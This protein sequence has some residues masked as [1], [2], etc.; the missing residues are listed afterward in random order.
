VSGYI[1]LHPQDAP[2]YG[3]PGAYEPRHPSGHPSDHPDRPDGHDLYDPHRGAGARRI[4]VVEDDAALRSLVAF[5]LEDE[6]Y[7]VDAVADGAAAAASVATRPPHLILLDLWLPRLG[8]QDFARR[9]LA[10]PGPHAPVLVLSARPLSEVV[11]AAEA[12]GAAGFLRKPFDLEDLMAA[13]RRTVTAASPEGVE[14]AG[15]AAGHSRQ[16]STPSR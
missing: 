2:A 11:G 13:V 9:Y 4:L 6:G 15:A 16:A 1:T 14:P 8:G 5:A 10:G 7:A 12:I 3:A